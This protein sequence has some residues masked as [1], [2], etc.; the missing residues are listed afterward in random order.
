MSLS[1]GTKVGAGA[2]VAAAGIPPSIYLSWDHITLYEVERH[3]VSD[4]IAF[5]VTKATETSNNFWTIK[6]K[7]NSFFN[8]GTEDDQYSWECKI[9]EKSGLNI[10][11]SDL[12]IF[13]SEASGNTYYIKKGLV[14]ACSKERDDKKSNNKKVKSELNFPDWVTSENWSEYLFG[15]DLLN[16]IEKEVLKDGVYFATTD[17]TGNK[18]LTVSATVTKNDANQASKNYTWSCEISTNSESF[19]ATNLNEKIPTSSS[20]TNKN[21]GKKRLVYA[22]SK[23]RKKVTETSVESKFTFPQNVSSGSESIY[24]FES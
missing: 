20:D 8:W 13:L 19:K 11:T 16:E 12:K 23:D 9:F 22:C 5:I 2:A 3:V 24:L 6:V 18:P 10:D 14:K 4:D 15:P 7:E 1:F 17:K 21:D